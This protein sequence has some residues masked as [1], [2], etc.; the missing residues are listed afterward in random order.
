MYLIGNHDLVHPE[1]GYACLEETI[2]VFQKAP[3]ELWSG[4]HSILCIGEDV[5]MYFNH[6][7]LLWHHTLGGIFYIP[8]IPYSCIHGIG[9][10]SC[11]IF[12]IINEEI[13]LKNQILEH[14]HT[15]PYITTNHV[16]M[17]VS[18]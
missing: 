4:A 10:L 13:Y 7:F 8:K 12:Q 5:V 16:H 17:L 11:I 15:T 3:P 2:V 9:L 6:Q 1:H 18:F 14:I